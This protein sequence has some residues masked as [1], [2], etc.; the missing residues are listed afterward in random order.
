VNNFVE[1]VGE[2]N[3]QSGL[4]DGVKLASIGPI[5]SAALHDAGLRVDVE[6]KVYTIPGL[7]EAIL[8]AH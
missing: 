3:V 6:A 4:L 1:L 2:E 5:T 7:V 8:K